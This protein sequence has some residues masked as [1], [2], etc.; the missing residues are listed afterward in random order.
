MIRR[1]AC[2]SLALLAASCVT[3]KPNFVPLYPSNPSTA[4]RLP[5]EQVSTLS[6]YV[7][8]VDGEDVSVRGKRFAL[9]PGCHI[10]GTPSNWGAYTPGGGVAV[11][12]QTGRW[13]FALP[14]RAGYRYQIEVIASHASG[15][16]GDLTIQGIET[17]AAGNR[18]AVFERM[19]DPQE[20]ES[21][22]AQAALRSDS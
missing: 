6:G 14:M 18:T 8:F 2:L 7:R 12:A 20:V 16:T 22:K 5:L 21:C 10:I 13:M 11:S 19:K 15:P 1:A 17:D 4:Q 9:L 3:A